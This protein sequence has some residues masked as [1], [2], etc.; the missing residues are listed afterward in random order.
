MGLSV[1]W[2]GHASFI[3]EA[4]G[5]AIYIDPYEGEYTEKADITLVTHSHHDHCDPSKI[6]KVRKDETIII[7]PAEC[8][9]K[10]GGKVKTLK[11]GE[12]ITIGNITVEAT[13]AYN[14]KRF[15]SPGK[16]FH[17]RGHGVGYII[18][19]K[20]KT[21]YHA[22][23]TD[24]IPEMDNLGKVDLALLPS[25]DTYTM[26]NSDAAKATLTIKPQVVIPMHR[27]D[28]DP[29]ELK[30][31][32]EAASQIRVVTLKPGQQFTLE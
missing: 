13:E 17:P 29:T 9:P 20:G 23:D 10:I 24:F 4:E 3:I 27:W 12:R 14:C 22:G 8:V 5:K 1:K 31:S 28:T 19:V 30:E 21:V 15:R 25:G 11:P 32:V 2:L 18:T 6:N 7:S 16:P 26:D